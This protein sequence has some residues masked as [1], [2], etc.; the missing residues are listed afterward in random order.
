M[1]DGIEDYYRDLRNA[2]SINDVNES[3]PP[4]DAPEVPP[5]V[6]PS[7]TPFGRVVN[8]NYL[9]LIEP[10]M[11][12]SNSKLRFGDGKV[13]VDTTLLYNS[14]WIYTQPAYELDCYFDTAVLFNCA[15]KQLHKKWVPARC[16][17]CFKTVARPQTLRELFAVLEI[18][19][20]MKHWPSKCGLELRDWV[21]GN[22]GAYWYARGLDAGR[23]CYA[24]VRD[25]IN[26]HPDL[27][28][29]VPVLLKRSCTEMEYTCGA[30][31]KWEVTP[32]QARVEA[33]VRG[34]VVI[35]PK[36]QFMPPHVDNYT[37]ERWYRHAYNIG[38]KTVFE[39]TGGIA[40]HPSYVTYHEQDE[41][42]EE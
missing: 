26:G 15:F 42:T 13:V 20:G 36:H 32:H 24:E 35:D 19:R 33:G 2:D 17:L 29:D 21:F 16:Q 1:S 18:Q 25:A 27:G 3:D 4:E 5:H 14:P 10:W 30:S 8:N 41:E 40:L 23:E 22:Y 12:R 9:K 37:I 34:I 11:K 38:D 7:D 39:Y 6:V 31:D 28:V